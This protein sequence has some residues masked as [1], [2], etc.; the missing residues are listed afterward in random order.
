MRSR[1][2]G[3]QA[4][5]VGDRRH[6]VHAV[7]VTFALSSTP[8]LSTVS[9][10]YS[11]IERIARAIPDP[12]LLFIGFYVLAL[13]AAALLGGTT[14]STLGPNGPVEQG[15]KPM[16]A[17]EHVRWIFDNALLANWLGFGNGVL[18]VI[19]IVT[20]AIGVAE[21]AG[22][23]GALIKKAGRQV[24]MRWMPLLLVFLGIMSSLATDAGYLVL[25]PWPACSTPHWGRTR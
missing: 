7:F 15:V 4:A 20:L 5:T 17:T 3:G 19:L 25:I 9:T 18:G 2:P 14:F 24:P 1:A 12:V 22:L 8:R 11:R 23:L 10:A 16:L 13:A 21:H 6:R